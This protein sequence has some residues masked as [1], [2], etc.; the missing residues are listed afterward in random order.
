MKI[1]ILLAILAVI[2]LI[3]CNKT[4]TKSCCTGNPQVAS[5]DSSFI[6]LPNIFTPNG[7]GINDI[8]YLRVKNISNLSF[9]VSK[10]LG[11][12]IFLSTDINSGWDGNYK[13]KPSKEKDYTFTLEA[14]TINGKSLSLS[15]NICLIRDNCA[16]GP[17]T[18]CF[19]DNQ[20]NGNTF[21]SNLPS[22]EDIKQCN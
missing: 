5:V 22:G 3:N 7:D 18:N 19:F 21:D 1:K 14:T 15:G 4:N 8:L 17:L 11:R 6:A 20:F 12:N 9:T 10:K 2:F 16:K 13:G